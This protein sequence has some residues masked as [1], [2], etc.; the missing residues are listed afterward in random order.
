MQMQREQGPLAGKTP[1]EILALL[2]PLPPL[3]NNQLPRWPDENLQKRFT[4]AS[5]L[6]LLKRAINFVEVLDRDEAFV[7]PDWKALDY[8]CGWGRIAS[9]MLTRGK[10]EQL[11]MCDAWKESLDLAR[12]NGFKNKLFGVSDVLR[13][14]EIP[15]NTY[16]FCYA[17]S[18][19]THLDRS[20]F[21]ANINYLIKSLKS[22]GRLYFTVRHKGFLDAMML[23]GR[24]PDKQVF[25]DD[26]FWHWTYPR[27][28]NYGETAVEP[29]FIQQLA[30]R[31]GEIAYLGVPEHEQH[32][33]RLTPRKT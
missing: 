19:F 29:K 4:G 7:R 1:E 13:E 11:D 33:Y 26:G 25:D 12:Q 21:D 3:V 24:V 30:S 14:G 16:D 5:G 31:W 9:Y 20:A 27:R 32:L 6:R 8:G 18:V 2:T 15:S 10:P 23:L 17:L 28:T 22:G